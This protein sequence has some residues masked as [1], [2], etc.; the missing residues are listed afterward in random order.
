MKYLEVL[1]KNAGFALLSVN[2]ALLLVLFLVQDPFDWFK[3]GYSGARS[4]VKLA[5]SDV[6]RITIKDPDF[7]GA[8]VNLIRGD[9]VPRTEKEEKDRLS[10]ILKPGKQ[11]YFWDL[12]VVKGGK[13]QGRHHADRDR[14][15]DLFEAIEKSRRYYGV[16]ASA[17]RVADLEMGRD[18]SGRPVCLNVILTAD[19]DYSLCVGRASSHGSENYVRLD[20]EDKIFLVQSNLRSAAGAGSTEYFRNRQIMPDSV[21]KESVTAVNAVFKNTEKN[22]QLGKSGDSWQ[23]LSPFPGKVNVGEVTALINDIVDWKAV[24]FIEKLPEDLDKKASFAV[25]L[26]YKRNLSDVETVRLDVLGQKDYSTYVI[27][28]PDGSLAEVTSVFL[29]HFLNP[30]EKLVPRE[31]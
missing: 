8:D 26:V 11:E 10:R 29:G 9:A 21:K 17:A 15:R 31:R 27:K 20:E 30:Q 7:G 6:T 19:R 16:E 28:A 23:M 4:I 2:V 18:S 13:G 1:R 24:R 14:I 3:G 25:E 22:V 12:E 5:Q